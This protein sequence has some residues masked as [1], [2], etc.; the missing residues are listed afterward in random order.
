MIKSQVC[1]TR[2]RYL[3]R[4]DPKST[5]EQLKAG[6]SRAIQQGVLPLFFTHSLTTK[7]EKKVPIGIFDS[8]CYKGFFWLSCLFSLSFLLIAL[9]NIYFLYCLGSYSSLN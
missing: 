2:G 1:S 6:L 4:G 5:T 7:E 9:M 8:L 3:I